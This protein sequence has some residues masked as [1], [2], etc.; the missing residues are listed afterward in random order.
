M[1]TINPTYPFCSGADFPDTG[2]P[3]S[4]DAG[5]H[6]W[7]RTSLLILAV[8]MFCM[9]AFT[10]RLFA[11]GNGPA[12]RAEALTLSLVALQNR[13][14]QANPAAR[15]HLLQAMTGTAA[16]RRQALADLLPDDTAGVLAAVLPEDIR[17][18]MPDVV[19]AQL[20]QS[21]VTEGVLEVLYQDQDDGSHRLRHYLNTGGKRLEL[22]FRGKPPEWLTGVR[23][24]AS[25]VLLD[26]ALVVDSS[27]T[28]LALTSSTTGSTVTAPVTTN[29]LPGTF[30]LQ[31]TV[32]LLVNFPANQAEPWTTDDAHGVVFGDVSDF[33]LE[34]SHGKTW[35]D[36][37]VFGWFTIPVDPAGCPTMDIAQHAQNA[38]AASGVDLSVYDRFIYAFPDIGCS[39]SGEATVGGSPSH[40]WFD[41]TLSGAGVVS[42]ELGHNLGLYH[43]HLLECGTD[44]ISSNCTTFEY[45]DAL[46]RMGGAAGGHF[47]AFQKSR[48]GWLDYLDSPPILDADTAGTYLLEPYALQLSGNKALRVLRDIDTTTSQRRW[49]FVEYR[50]AVGFDSFLGTS[51]YGASVMNG[52]VIR[53]G[54]EGDAGSSFLLDMTPES[55]HYDWD[56]LAL[57]A[58]NRYT[59]PST[60]VTIAADTL[61]STGAAVSVSFDQAVCIPQN[62]S[63]QISPAQGPWVSPGTSVTYDLTV[64][65]NDA[66][67]CNSTSYDLSVMT[68]PGWTAVPGS[69]QVQLAPGASSTTSITVSSPQTEAGGYYDID[70]SATESNGSG[71]TGTATATYVIDPGTVVPGCTV[72]APVLTITPVSQSGDPG[73]ALTYDISLTS[74]DSA[75]CSASTYD[76]TTLLGAWN[77]SVAPGNLTLVPGGSGQASLSVTSQASSTAG[78]YNLQVVV[79]DALESG[80]HANANLTYVVN[81][82]S[83]AD[84]IAPTAPTGV[85]ASES[86]KQVSLSWIPSSDNVA[87]TGYRIYRDGLQVGTAIDNTYTDRSGDTGVVYAYT[88]DA[89]DAEGNRSAPSNPVM[90]GKVKTNGKGGSTTGGGASS[91]GRKGK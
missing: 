11:A 13:Y 41:G 54:T 61:D 48:L 30:G 27:D 86:Q 64:T 20:E 62:P 9:A 46:D 25:G 43:S 78:S 73:S 66:T 24:S 7:R 51:R 3:S 34:N 74:A 15:Q 87:V 1:Q 6:D 37:D 56:D 72:Q 47:N 70:F 5:C 10:G 81:P 42:H 77:G 26:D 83:Q 40:A 90:A 35:L 84:T 68:P 71:V 21:A 57:P 31:R 50:Q 59:D 52:L 45:G 2:K 63:V 17:D 91:K 80:H 4:I 67:A 82:V 33:F 8:L 29:V 18:R 16:T 38:A 12:S 89:H 85:I 23:V 60:G 14:D 65:S 28:I 76:L 53:V 49:Y 88:I 44:A 39:W 69:G 58:G 32:V 79:S 36:G 22:H 19:R 75:G 55:Q